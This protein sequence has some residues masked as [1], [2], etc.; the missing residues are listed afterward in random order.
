MRPGKIR[1]TLLA[2][3]IFAMAM[4][5]AG[6]SEEQ[7]PAEETGEQIDEAAE[8]LQDDAGEAAEE[9]GDAVEDAT[10]Q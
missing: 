2:A 3:G 8:E 7:G 4:A 6:C 1:T 10:D 9:A 5:V